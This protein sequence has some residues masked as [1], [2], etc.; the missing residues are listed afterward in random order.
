MHCV[1]ITICEKR[2]EGQKG[3]K[4][5]PHTPENAKMERLLKSEEWEHSFASR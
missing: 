1:K 4:N 3:T 2:L 5:D